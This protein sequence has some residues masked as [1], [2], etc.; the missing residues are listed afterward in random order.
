M[1]C[2]TYARTTGHNL[3]PND[4]LEV[5]NDIWEVEA[6]PFADGVESAW[7]GEFLEEYSRPVYSY[8]SGLPTEL[9]PHYKDGMSLLYSGSRWYLINLQGAKEES[10]SEYWVR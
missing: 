7:E 6:V 3:T 1:F 5:H 4:L 2:V 8:V 10:A 9:E